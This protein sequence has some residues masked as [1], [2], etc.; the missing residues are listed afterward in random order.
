MKTLKATIYYTGTPE[1]RA[2]LAEELEA[3]A[4]QFD[5]KLYIDE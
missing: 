3:L 4:E 5:V 1:D 2:E